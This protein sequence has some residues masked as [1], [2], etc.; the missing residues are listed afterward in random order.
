[1]LDEGPYPP[2]EMAFDI[3]CADVCGNVGLP[4][5]QRTAQFHLPVAGFIRHDSRTVQLTSAGGRPSRPTSA[6]AAAAD[7]ALQQLVSLH[8][9]TVTHSLVVVL[10][11]RVYS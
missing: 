1:M 2:R 7:A 5:G 11:V 6:S 9:A 4:R 10:T 3:C 8:F